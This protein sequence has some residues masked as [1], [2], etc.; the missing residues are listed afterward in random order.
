MTSGSKNTFSRCPFTTYWSPF[1]SM[2]VTAPV[3]ETE[4]TT[5]GPYHLLSNFPLPKSLNLELQSRT[6]SPSLNSLFCNRLSYHLFILS[7]EIDALLYAFNLNSSNSLIW[8]LLLIPAA[9]ASKFISFI[10]Q[11]ALCSSSTGKWHVFP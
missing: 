11:Y 1:A 5:Y 10:A 3:G 9:S 7:L 8:I 4:C 2:I 6:L